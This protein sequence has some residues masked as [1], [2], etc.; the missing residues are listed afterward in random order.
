MN[1][2]NDPIS[3][4]NQ[5]MQDMHDPSPNYT[6]IA[7]RNDISVNEVIAYMKHDGRIV[8]L[9]NERIEGKNSYIKKMIRLANGYT[10]FKR[11]RNRSMYCENYYEAYSRE[12]LK[13][14][15]KRKFP[16]RRKK[17]E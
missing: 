3:I 11:F 7:Q 8:R 6:I 1:G 2:F 15:V 13:N 5:V 12:P 9:S 4:M 16:K 14:T 10:N 17:K